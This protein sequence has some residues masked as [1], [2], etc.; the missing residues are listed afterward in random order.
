M[1]KKTFWQKIKSWFTGDSGSKPKRTATKSSS[2]TSRASRVSNYGGGYSS[3][4]RSYGNAYRED[5]EKKKRKQLEDQNKQTT[6]KLAEISKR[7]DS[8]SSGKKSAQPK[9]EP[10]KAKPLTGR[11]KA[12]THLARKTAPDP[13]VEAAKRSHD[14]LQSALEERREKKE[15]A[16]S[17]YKDYKKRVKDTRHEAFHK[18]THHRYDVAQEGI[19]K[20]EKERR[21]QNIRTAPLYEMMRGRDDEALDVM[22]ANMDYMKGHTSAMRGAAN[23]MS[24][25]AFDLAQKR[26]NKGGYKEAEEYY[27]ANKDPWAEAGG[28]LIGGALLYGGTAPTFNAL[29][30]QG[31]ERAAATE[32]GKRLGAK[33]LAELMAGE[34]AKS[35]FARALVGSGL[36]DSSIGLV[37]STM[38]AL[39]RDDLETPGDY[40]KEIAKWQGY[41]Y[42]FGL[43]MNTLGYGLNRVAPGISDAWSEFA[44]ESRKMRFV[45][46]GVAGDEGSRVIMN[47]GTTR[48]SR[49]QGIQHEAGF[50]P[51]K[52]TP[53]AARGGTSVERML[54]EADDLDAFINANAKNPNVRAYVVDEGNGR[55]GLE[56]LWRDVRIAKHRQGIR[57]MSLDEA[58][59]VLERG[60]PDS[61]RF[62]W[63][64]NQNSLIKP[65]LTN[66]LARDPDAISAG[67]SIAYHNYADS[68]P[69]GTAA[70][71][72]DEW[73]V[74]PQ[75]MY[76]GTHGQE[77][78]DE[79]IFSAFTPDRRVAEKFAG[80]SKDAHIE[81]ITVRP[82]DTLGG[83][84]TSGEQEILVPRETIE[85]A[86][87]ATRGADGVAVDDIR[88]GEKT[89]PK[90][91]KKGKGK[92]KTKTEPKAN[93]EEITENTVK[94][95]G[96]A[97][98]A[99]K[100]ID[101]LM[102]ERK[103]IMDD[104]FSRN[105]RSD[106]AKINRIKEIDA[107]IERIKGSSA[108]EIT[109]GS[110]KKAGKKSK[111]S[112]KITDDTVKNADETSPK[113]GKSTKSK[114]KVSEAEKL[115]D[116][117]V[118]ERKELQKA[119]ETAKANGEDT[120]QIL[121]DL[122]ENDLLIKDAESKIAKAKGKSEPPKAKAKG[123]GKGK[124][125]AEAEPKVEAKAKVE[126][127]AEAEPNGKPKK[128]PLKTYKQNRKREDPDAV[129]DEARAEKARAE[130]ARAKA[131]P[132]A[133]TSTPRAEEPT[134]EATPSGERVETGE[135][136][137]AG[138]GER[139]EF[140]RGEEETA[141]E[142]ARNR[143]TSNN[144]ERATQETFDRDF[145]AFSR[146]ASENQ[147]KINDLKS[148]LRAATSEEEKAALKQQIDALNR[149]VKSAYNQ[150]SLRYH[151]DRGG[152]NEWMGR[153]NEA[154]D[155]FKRGNYQSRPFSGASSSTRSGARTSADGGSTPPP[156][157][158]G[159]KVN[160]G[161]DGFKKPKGKARKGYARTV[162]SVEQAVYKKRERTT[163]Y[164]KGE[165]VVKDAR[166]RV[167]DSHAPFEDVARKYV[168]TDP[169][170]FQ[171]MYG[172]INAHRSSGSIATQSISKKQVNYMGDAYEDGKSLLEIYKGMDEETENAFDAYL[173]LK[174]SPDRLREGTPIFDNVF[175]KNV[176][177][178]LDDSE[179]IQR[180]ID[181]LLREHPDFEKRAEDVYKY[182]QHELK[183]MVDAGLVSPETAAKWSKDHP[184]YVPTHRAGYGGIASDIRN[185]TIGATG[186]KAA[187][188]SD[189]DI[190]SIREQIEEMTHRNWEDITLNDM[191]KDVFHDKIPT[192]ELGE[193]AEV[194]ERALADNISIS[195]SAD[196]KKFFAEVSIKG[197]RYRFEIEKQFVD[198]LEDWSKNGRF[199]IPFL[200]TINEGVSKYAG[201]WKNL[202]T[203]WSPWFLIK[204]PTK[205]IPEAF[206]NSRQG[207]EFAKNFIP[208]IKDLATG[209]KYSTAL[210]NAGISQSSFFDLDKALTKDI[211][212]RKGFLKPLGF[213]GDKLAGANQFMEMLPR[214]AE[215]MA[216]F[217]KAGV[218]LEKADKALRNR[219]AA[220][221][222]DVTVNFGRSG[223]FG[224]GLNRGYVPF[225]NASAQGWSKFARNFQEQPGAKAYLSFGAK[226]IT[227]GMGLQ[228]A[229]NFMLKDNPNYQ[230]VS[231]RDK[232]NNLIIP[233]PIQDWKTTDTFVRIPKSR[234][235]A[236]LGLPAVNMFN[237]N[238]M[239][240]ADM[241]KVAND[242][243]AP[244]SP[245]ESHFAAPIVALNKTEQG[246][247]WYGTP[248]VPEALKKLEKGA[249]YDA[250]TS[251]ISK[252]VG[253][254]S[255]KV[256]D[257][258]GLDEKYQ[259]SPKKLDYL[260]DAEFGAAAD[261]ILPM[262]T[263]S[264]QG[265]GKGIQKYG[266]TL[267]KTITTPFTIDSTVQN[268]LSTR[269]YD[270]FERVE[271]AKNTRGGE[272]NKAEYDRLNSYSTEISDINKAIRH[273]QG[274]NSVTKQAD[275]RGLQ[276]V[277][278]QLM[279]DALDGNEPPTTVKKLDAVRKYVGTT[280][281]VNNFGSNADRDAMKIYGKH[282]YGDLSEKEMEKK[283]NAD[284]GF[285]KGVRAIGELEDKI[286]SEAGVKSN[287]TLMKAV[288][289]ADAG[290]DDD[291]FAAYQCSNKSRT[292]T[293]TKTERA[294]NYL[295]EG[296]SEEEFA[297]LEKARKTYG[298]LTD[299]N[300]E[301]ETKKIDDQLANGQIS[302][303]EYNDRARGIE[304]NA[305]I[306]YVGLATSLAQANAPERGY[307]LYDIKPKNIQKGL[308]LAA[309]GFSARD[310]RDMTKA[311]DLNGN[312]YPS[313]QEV[314]DYVAN[315]NVAD[316]ATLF[317][318]LY[319]YQGSNP[320]GTPKNYSRSQ[321]AQTGARNGITPISNERG[322]FDIK[323]DGTVGKNG[324][325]GY[326]SHYSYYGHR[327]RGGGS[328]GKASVPA[329][330]KIAKGSLK[331]GQA[332]VTKTRT[333]S[334]KSTT[335]TLARVEAK[336]DLPTAKYSKK[337]G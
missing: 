193:S 290:A 132:K 165:K 116:D 36:Q 291:L 5:E 14:N 176:A 55:G 119:Y 107:E 108:E 152:S 288:A 302:I 23:I 182:L 205:D 43:G 261:L 254:A 2:N 269:F 63:F 30:A 196:S 318:A 192:T 232:A 273:V 249:Q 46:E 94:N 217:E 184:F 73:L 314:I 109:E 186:Q 336:I 123:K 322:E 168:R 292:E 126:P 75:K 6:A 241:I 92:G 256:T 34:G 22:K 190:R 271:K 67:M 239:S 64:R 300:Q 159:R 264:K 169:E 70:M 295:K 118:A 139:T 280:F 334:G 213:L 131:E 278:N 37:D 106:P 44:D 219:A 248:I 281:A 203:E 207:K 307:R 10:P 326:R 206:I 330:K 82:I 151:P 174:H 227:L 316:K 66:Y 189:Y 222:A 148:Q 138:A 56:K 257:A 140:R 274:G 157:P 33:K 160:Y 259:I 124:T 20:E 50:K 105:E 117:L 112:S 146:K 77:L 296:G 211:S 16:R 84:A 324:W 29:G 86:R 102:A 71:P 233:Y 246:E 198:A 98:E 172:S 286:V 253:K 236:V 272:K 42:L 228:A 267:G 3:S 195:K 285:Y 53:K 328:S 247:T 162:D 38:R 308:N 127:K 32:I 96:K 317:D 150:A 72:F 212:G 199:G 187:K 210:K 180:E 87:Q 156:P 313:R 325:S 59:A 238:K 201:V 263:P 301:D 39:Q 251:N 221:A 178:K 216:T 128:D 287:T 337:R 173:L 237:E 88:M 99:S 167:F 57:E 310:Y 25:S 299:Y 181:R 101:D 114:G 90:A 304:Y 49:L 4:Y 134:A 13:K 202:I 289:L 171:N 100:E 65:K 144:R 303:E 218:P 243:V 220:N 312:G 250:N 277:K 197:K 270:E 129:F 89:P 231:G 120:K 163:L 58:N 204:N 183:N 11:D 244:I 121:D 223:S 161:E 69:R 331:S 319:Y 335:P 177:G 93:A 234:F 81:E 309:M 7:T 191:L 315:S 154:Y 245:F 284:E 28:G 15:M 19:S 298:K 91:K 305:N 293:A 240:Y 164:Q 235:A 294:R 125:T 136:A 323:D 9:V 78:L 179:V 268:N 45:P 224:K 153:F 26:L 80:A 137:N 166:M 321:A 175:A 8:L 265:G 104:I 41:N 113:K 110:V 215:Y 76:R 47:G 185:S 51:R 111:K 95:T 17:E 74:T 12:V 85:S 200:D 48:S 35:A 283:I 266:K 226:V 230:I 31:V 122:Q 18:A 170:R 97:S 214:L 135:N 133:E 79:D 149:E 27:Q 194:L 60:V 130:K 143:R 147:T 255:A 40:L 332:L 229:N 145:E 103:Q 155:S 54:A 21:K 329:P 258:L 297:Q 311:L 279:Q 282:K 262:T 188:G 208:A 209:G 24:M 333:S 68:L 252:A 225:F 242:A 158:R 320:F 306:S 83:Y 62:E 61:T 1:A 115:R 260:L 327:R 275:I 276:K 141:R 52:L 142:Q